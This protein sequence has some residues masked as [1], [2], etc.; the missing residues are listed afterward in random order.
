MGFEPQTNKF[1]SLGWMA[2]GADPEDQAKSQSVSLRFI[3]N[4]RARTLHRNVICHRDQKAKW[5][6][7]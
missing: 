5:M 6:S 7:C 3:G 2:D 1:D 4:N